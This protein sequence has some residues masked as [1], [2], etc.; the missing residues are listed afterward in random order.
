LIAERCGYASLSAFSD[1]F[2]KHFSQ[3]PLQV[4]RYDK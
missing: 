3:S 1:R 4:R 2:H